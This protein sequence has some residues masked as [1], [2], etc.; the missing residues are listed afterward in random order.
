[1]EVIFLK[2][3]EISL[4]IYKNLSVNGVTSTIIYKMTWGCRYAVML[5]SALKLPVRGQNGASCLPFWLL[6]WN[7]FLP[8]AIPSLEN[9]CITIWIQQTWSGDLIWNMPAHFKSAWRSMPWRKIPHS[10][11]TYFLWKTKCWRASHLVGLIQVQTRKVTC[12]MTLL[13]LS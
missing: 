7:R 6:R 10:F 5:K 4:I 2:N 3:L 9:T 13:A 11:K 1:M 12:Y 8:P